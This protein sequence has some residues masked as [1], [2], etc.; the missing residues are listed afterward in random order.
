MSLSYGLANPT[1][2]NLTDWN[3]TI[4]GPPNTN[5][6]NRLY[7][8]SIKCGEKYPMEPPIVRFTSKI[9]INC[10]NKNN[11]S[12]DNLSI[13]KT[14]KSGYCIEDILKQIKNEMATP[15]NKKLP[16]PNEGETYI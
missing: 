14:W 1:D 7:F 6:D 5:F 12:V 9:N 4:L 13:L 11:G 15:N 16:Q 8:L 3:G 2:N 10:A